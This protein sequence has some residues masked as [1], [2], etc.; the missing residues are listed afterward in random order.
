MEWHFQENYTDL[1]TSAAALNWGMTV[2]QVQA[3]VTPK[4][5]RQVLR[6]GGS[7]Y[8]KKL[9]VGCGYG[10]LSY[11]LGGSNCY[12]IDTNSHQKSLYEEYTEGGNFTCFD[13]QNIPFKDWEFDVAVSSLVFKHIMNDKLHQL[14]KEVLRV[15]KHM[16]A[17]DIIDD[18]W[19]HPFEKKHRLYRHNLSDLDEL[20][21]T[22][23]WILKRESFAPKDPRDA[24]QQ[25]YVCHRH[26]V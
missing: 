25:L 26:F 20:I 23:G 15:T 8:G 17:F 18:Q 4:W 10:R 12:G 22:Q 2:E 11:A 9:D 3:E 19:P 16:F 14:V 5:I 1:K 6:L 7:F 24:Y 13:G 21:T